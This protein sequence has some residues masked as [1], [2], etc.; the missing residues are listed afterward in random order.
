MM[1]MCDSQR[2]LIKYELD[3]N[4]NHFEI[5]CFQLA[6]FYK[7]YLRVSTSGKQIGIVGIEHII[8]QKKVLTL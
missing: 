3:I 8:Y 4:I 1:T 6:F 5:D 2:Y 7:S